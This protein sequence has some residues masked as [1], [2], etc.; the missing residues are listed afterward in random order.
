MEI[1]GKQSAFDRI[2]R[3]AGAF[4]ASDIGAATHLRSVLIEADAE[5]GSVTLTAENDASAIRFTVEEGIDVLEG[6]RLLVDGNTLKTALSVID[7][8]TRVVLTV[9]GARELNVRGGRADVN[10]PVTVISDS[11]AMLPQVMAA[12]SAGV[13]VAAASFVTGY[14]IGSAAH[15]GQNKPVLNSVHISAIND[16]AQLRFLSCNLQALA[17]IAVDAQPGGDAS[18]VTVV[19]PLQ[20]GSAVEFVNRGTEVHLSHGAEGDAR[21]LHLRVRE[22]SKNEGTVE[23]YH[24]RLNTVAAPHKDYPIDQMLPKMSLLFGRAEH[25]VE[26]PKHDLLRLFRNAD[27]ILTL[28]RAGQAKDIAVRISDAD[29]AAIVGGENRFED[30]VGVRTFS[31][32]AAE[33]IFRWGL[34]GDMIERYPGDDLRAALIRTKKDG[35]FAALALV[36][37]GT[38]LGDPTP[39]SYLAVVPLAA[40]KRAA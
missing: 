11:R 27:R 12:D 34:Y 4:T 8:D 23:L 38:D 24:I 32:D 31:G 6:G 40:E 18:F 36:P 20:I 39:D 2:V 33:F 5:A 9:I 17:T 14:R 29:L 7:A 26:V 16:G 13:S 15:A 19:D 10:V 28:N 25:L 22:S 3:T 21:Q 30:S 37:A 1:A 35:P